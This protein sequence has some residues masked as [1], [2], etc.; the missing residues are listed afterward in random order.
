MKLCQ[1]TVPYITWLTWSW[2]DLYFFLAT[3][4]PGTRYH[5]TE[6]QCIHINKK[7][8]CAKT[9]RWNSLHYLMPVSP[10]QKEL[11]PLMRQWKESHPQDILRSGEMKDIAMQSVP[12]KTSFLF[13]AAGFEELCMTR[14]LCSCLCLPPGKRLAAA[15]KGELWVSG[16]TATA[17]EKGKMTSSHISGC[18]PISPGP[19]QEWQALEKL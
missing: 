2:T 6:L 16:V 1:W 17:T 4:L 8:D 15:D 10:N 12:M 7:E 9:L 13:G 18:C 11:S 5:H 3:W 14:S 19:L